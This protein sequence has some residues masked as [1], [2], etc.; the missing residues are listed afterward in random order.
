M[1]IFDYH[2]FIIYLDF[3]FVQASRTH[4]QAKIVPSDEQVCRAPVSIDYPI[5][6]LQ[7]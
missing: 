4:A 6:E 3:H 1:I 5:R 7:T 2:S